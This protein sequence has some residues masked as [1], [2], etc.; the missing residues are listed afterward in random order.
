MLAGQSDGA[1]AAAFAA[2]TDPIGACGGSRVAGV[3]AF[4]ADPVPVRPGATATVLAVTG[5]ADEVNPPAHTRALFDEAP[6]PAYLLTSRGDDH[7][8]PSTDSPHRSAIDAVVI[9]YLRATL[10][11]DPEARVR[12]V[13]DARGPGLELEQ[14]SRP[15]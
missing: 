10:L 2:L 13:A 15:A 11:S 14:R 8:Q 6:L 7:L 5:S 4:S 1:T 9:D 12:I 3:V